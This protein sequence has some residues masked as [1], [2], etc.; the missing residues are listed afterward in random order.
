LT[1]RI[2]D[3]LIKLISI[4][5]HDKQRRGKA[6]PAANSSGKALDMLNC[7]HAV[8]L[9]CGQLCWSC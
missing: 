2:I 7:Y 3:K 1:W 6:S 8:S 4:G 5:R 9:N